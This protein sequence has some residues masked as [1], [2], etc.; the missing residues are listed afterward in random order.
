MLA[1]LFKQLSDLGKPI[2][3]SSKAVQ[4]P[5]VRASFMEF[6]FLVTEK[7]AGDCGLLTHQT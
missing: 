1:Q 2:P 5:T 3:L 6:F 4:Y 7:E